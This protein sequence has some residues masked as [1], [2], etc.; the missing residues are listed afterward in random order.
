MKSGVGVADET[1]AIA[2]DT[3]TAK[4]IVYNWGKYD[5]ANDVYLGS[6]FK[7]GMDT[8]VDDVRI[9]ASYK[10]NG[11]EKSETVAYYDMEDSS[12]IVAAWHEGIAADEMIVTGYENGN[13]EQARN[14]GGESQRGQRHRHPRGTYDG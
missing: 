1:G 8:I 13:Y 6:W 5:S 10:E 2:A 7:Y 14:Y 3:V 9:T 11:S 12:K 4:V